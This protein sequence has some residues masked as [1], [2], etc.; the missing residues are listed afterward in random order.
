[1]ITGFGKQ[2]WAE[3]E[4]EVDADKRRLIIE[5]ARSLF[6]TR[7]YET[8]TMAEVARSAGVAVGTVYLYFKNKNDLLYGVK[9]EWDTEFLRFMAR[10][11]IQATPHHLRARPL[12]EA[13]F[14]LCAQQTEMVQL[15][16]VQ[17]EMVGHWHTNDGGRVQSAIEAMFNEAQSAGAF[18]EVDSRAASVIAYGMV[19]QALIQCFIIEDGQDQPLYID[20][21]VDAMEQWLV[22]P[23]LLKKM[24]AEQKT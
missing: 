12:I 23:E 8:T 17:P 5:A 2:R 13:V 10:P 22:K 24:R 21:V 14:S 11:E 7:G 16:G 19:N 1:M 3:Q 15:M 18:R 20:A 4:R 6:T 9:D